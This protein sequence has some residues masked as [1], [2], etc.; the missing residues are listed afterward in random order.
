MMSSYGVGFESSLKPCKIFTTK[1][2]QQV[3]AIGWLSRLGMFYINLARN[4]KIILLK[5][6]KRKPIA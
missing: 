2:D 6:L 5:K 1:K 3:A 4:Q